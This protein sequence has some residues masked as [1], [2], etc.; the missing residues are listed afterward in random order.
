MAF[1]T[2]IYTFIADNMASH[3]ATI[4][5]IGETVFPASTGLDY[6]GYTPPEYYEG[7]RLLP[8]ERRSAMLR[9]ARVCINALWRLDACMSLNNLGRCNRGIL[10]NAGFSEEFLDNLA[11]L[12][13]VM[14]NDYKDLQEKATEWLAGSDDPNVSTS[15][16]M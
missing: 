5:S 16:F 7:A 12:V 8:R 10:R 3:F 9:N 1:S 4:N 2:D 15:E 14:T 11:N 13:A 6:D